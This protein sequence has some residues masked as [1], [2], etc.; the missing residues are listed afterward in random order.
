MPISTSSTGSAIVFCGFTRGLTDRAYPRYDDPRVDG[1]PAF[2]IDSIR[3]DN[4][5][6]GVHEQ[7]I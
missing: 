7:P 1:V 2:V 6:I 3:A 5:D 4:A